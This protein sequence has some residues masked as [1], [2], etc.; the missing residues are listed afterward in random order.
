VKLVPLSSLQRA[1]ESFFDFVTSIGWGALALAVA[2][3]I[4]KSL[5]RTRA[6]RNILA[7]AHPG[8]TVRWRNVYGAYVAGVGVNALLPARGG[9]VLKLYLI[10]RRI[11][12]AAYPTLAATLLVETIFDL[13]VSSLLLLWAVQLGVLPGLEAL[14]QLPAV[15]WFWLF[16]RPRLAAGVAVGLLVLG[17][18]AGIWAAARFSAFRARVA[19]GFAILRTPRLYV[20]GV[21]AWQAVDWALR[22]ATVLFFLRAFGLDATVMNA[23]LVQVTQSLSTVLPLTPAG[24]GTEQALIVYVFAGDAPASTVLSFSVGMKL[25]LVLVNVVVGLL[26]IAIML[27]TLRWQRHLGR[28]AAEA[29]SRS[30]E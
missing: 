7:A 6:W 27:R 16:E 1:F 5:A 18:V 25:V 9:D 22:L 13:V 10:H 8:S 11:D 30:D 14:P 28:D 2:C 4:A 15:D 3:H 20:R 24:I 23:L 12:G 17:F 29:G 19:D 21:L 26:A